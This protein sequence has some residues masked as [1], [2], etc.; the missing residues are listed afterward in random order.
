MR[1][2]LA[3]LARLA[4]P[5]LSIALLSLATSLPAFALTHKHKAKSSSHKKQQVKSSTRQVFENLDKA[6][7]AEARLIE[8]Y[9]LI[10]KGQNRDALE[11][12]TRL[13]SDVPNFQLA[14]LVYGDLLASRSRPIS[15]IGDVP[16]DISKSANGT[17]KDLREESVKRMKALTE[18]PQPGTIPSQFLELSQTSR[19]AIAVDTSRSRLYLFENNPSGLRLLGDYYISVGKLGTS[20]N[21]EG[22]QRTPL[23]VYFITS[24]LDPKSLKNFY[25]SGALPLNYPNALDLRRGKTGGG[26]WLHGTPSTQ[27]ARAPQSTDGCVVLSNP[28]LEHVIHSVEIRSTPV[29]IATQLQ[30]ITPNDARPVRK[31]FED[32]LQAWRNAKSLGKLNEVVNFYAPD[33]SSNGKTL[34]QWMV[35]VKTEMQK[36]GG[37]AILIRDVSLLRWVDDAETMVVT[38]G[39]ITEGERG[40]QTKR[41]YWIRRNNQWKMFYEGIV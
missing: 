26:I 19:H 40:G 37:K 5:L 38:F 17:L 4:T 16:P 6:G 23:G 30:W 13:V 31:S 29:V 10:G 34:E 18:R 35:Q 32:T 1:I 36:S 3:L 8:I 2:I 7:I 24:S 28:D 33:F 12:A 25:G 27:Y 22:D 14:Q 41:Q 11:K 39:E 21:S 15:L 20:K 9:G